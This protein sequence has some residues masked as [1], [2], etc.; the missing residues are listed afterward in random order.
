MNQSAFTILRLT[1]ALIALV[2][3]TNQPYAFYHFTRWLLMITCLWGT[4]R[5]RHQLWPS[6]APAYT[7]I[8]ILFNPIAPFHF[9]KSTWHLL[10]AL[11]AITLLASIA[12]PYLRPTNPQS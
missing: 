3:I 10:D 9:Q 7:L 4:Y 6:F 1:A 11:A 8:A 12:A 2:A 5:H